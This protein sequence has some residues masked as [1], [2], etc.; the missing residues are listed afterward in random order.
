MMAAATIILCR[1]GFC[2]E[3]EGSFQLF[4]TWAFEAVAKRLQM[5]IANAIFSFMMLI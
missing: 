3:M 2:A 5:M 1:T 4:N